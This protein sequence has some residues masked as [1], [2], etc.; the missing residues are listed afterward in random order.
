MSTVK[1]YDECWDQV[2][3]M[4]NEPAAYFPQIKA[5]KVSTCRRAEEWVLRVGPA[6]MKVDTNKEEGKVMLTCL[7]E[8]KCQGCVLGG[9]LKDEDKRHR[10]WVN[11]GLRHHGEPFLDGTFWRR[12][13]QA[14]V[15]RMEGSQ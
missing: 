4:L 8:S 6:T 7:P 1:G 9:V 12:G 2:M 5:D 11:S 10:I 13:L 3:L 15:D 14:G